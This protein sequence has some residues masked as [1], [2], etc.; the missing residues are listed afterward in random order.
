MRLGQ[1]A[2]KLA[3]RPDQI[4]EFLAKKN[5]QIEDGSNTRLEDNHV[6]LVV[7]KFA[8][9]GFDITTQEVPTQDVIPE[10]AARVA[11]PALDIDKAEATPLP[12][13]DSVVETPTSGEKIEIIKAPKVEL[14]GLKVLGKIDLP[15]PKRKEQTTTEIQPNAEEGME[16]KPRAERTKS[17]HSRTPRPNP[18]QSKNPIALQREREEMEAQRKREEAK[19]LEKEKRAQHY[20]N[21]VKVVTP[22]K[23]SKYDQ[24]VEEVAEP[25]PQPK[26]LLGKF[27]RWFTT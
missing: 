6:A 10:I 7:E 3:L 9:P 2:R 1:L 21:K 4:V 11:I 17:V 23:T 16:I 22:V 12:I 18:R 8:P 13:E 20:F 5:I 27:L 14:S 15:E 26:T 24:V 25:I 19:A